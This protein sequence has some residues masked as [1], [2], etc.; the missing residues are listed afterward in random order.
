M[1]RKRE[2]AQRAAEEGA[3]AAQARARA[4]A[5]V[6][7]IKLDVICAL[8]NLGY[9]ADEACRAV[10]LCDG[11]DASFEQECAAPCHS[12]RNLATA[13]PRR[14][15]DGMTCRRGSDQ[16]RERRIDSEER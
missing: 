16:N 14:S 4:D 11:P 12:S 2:E 6:E 13:E 5:T 1:R 15:R 3:A 7:E 10:A 8:R 9:R